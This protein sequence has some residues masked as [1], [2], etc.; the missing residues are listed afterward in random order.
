[1][2]FILPNTRSP[3]N[4]RQVKIAGVD[5]RST[6]VRIGFSAET[7]LVIT[8][9]QGIDCMEKLDIITDVEIEN[10]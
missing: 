6:Y 5:L 4:S 7:E 2:V 8:D 1:M 10:L 9:T 3:K